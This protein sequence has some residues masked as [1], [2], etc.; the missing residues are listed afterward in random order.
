MH[1][2][3]FYCDQ[4]G[5]IVESCR[6]KVRGFYEKGLYKF[7]GI[8]YA[9]ARRYHSPEPVDAWD[10]VKDCLCYGYTCP[11]IHNTS[12]ERMMIMLEFRYW[13]QD[14][15]CLNLNV[16]TQNINNDV[17]KPVM[18]FIHGG[19]F[20]NGSSI[21]HLT[22]EP[23][24]LVKDEDIVLVSLNHRLNLLGYFNLSGYGDQYWNTVNLGMEDIVAALKWVRENI[25]R[26]GGDPDNVTI[27]G[28]SGGGMKCTVL[29]QTPSTQGLYHK[30]ILESGVTSNALPPCSF[31]DSLKVADAVVAE[32]GLS[33]ECIADIEDPEKVPYAKLRE[34]FL[35]VEPGLLAKGVNTFWAP[36]ANSWYLG[37]PREAGP[38]EILKNTPMIAG[39]A[40]AETVWF[41]DVYLDPTM[42][43]EK[44][45]AAL[46][47]RYG[48]ETD[49]LLELYRKAYPEKEDMEYYYL[50]TLF[51]QGTLEYLD[52]KSQAGG[53]PI[54]SY[55]LSYD[56]K[57]N[58]KVPAWHAADHPL[59]FKSYEMCPVM[60]DDFCETLSNQIAGSW[61]AFAHTGNP[62][63]KYLT[64]EWKPYQKGNG[65]YTY[66]FDR[67]NDLRD[68]YDRELVEETV[69]VFR[70]RIAT[71]NY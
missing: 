4:R 8:P 40:F 6:G 45:K 16:F 26:F 17:K 1:T 46:V 10:D 30:A 2:T 58:G 52:C 67:N 44:K 31:E 29:M 57:V 39:T 13:P 28:Q 60:Q 3:D 22:Y 33:K 49:R 14:E 41:N 47:S 61:G 36:A 55:M 20:A 64:C 66:I 70:N 50:D 56:F 24:N 42:S 68:G 32:L 37:D 62:N 18:V 23:E 11:T 63:N 71:E 53:A 65:E 51:R 35:K 7:R 59:V 12:K 69:K 34:A 5:P 19:A 43:D 9:K 15:D 25:S 38:S 21:E 54:Y 27:F 48:S